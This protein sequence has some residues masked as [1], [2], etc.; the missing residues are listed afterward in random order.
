MPRLFASFEIV[1]ITMFVSKLCFRHFT[2]EDQSQND[3]GDQQTHT[4]SEIRAV[5]RPDGRV[6]LCYRE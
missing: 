4:K 2:F 5:T 6:G 1:D 3:N